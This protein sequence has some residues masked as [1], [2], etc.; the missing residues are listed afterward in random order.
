VHAETTTGDETVTGLLARW[1]YGDDGAAGELMPLVYAELHRLAA[2][3]MRGERRDHTLQATA[4]VHEAYLRLAAG[5]APDWRDRGHFYAVAASTMRRVLVDHAR[6]LGAERRGGGRARVALADGDAPAGSKT[7]APA[8]DLLDLDRALDELARRDARKAR[9]VELRYF[10]GLT[11]AETAELLA[12][13]EPTVRLDARL[14]RAWLYVRLNAPPAVTG[15]A[16]AG[17]P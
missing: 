17:A 11:A 6:R 12:V 2:G 9:V 7:A 16:A 1:R 14:A 13:S 3:A 10:A 8:V 15:A 4:L 5:A